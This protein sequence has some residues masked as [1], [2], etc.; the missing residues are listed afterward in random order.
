[1]IHH[2]TPTFLSLASHYLYLPIGTSPHQEYNQL[3]SHKSQ[4]LPYYLTFAFLYLF[5]DSRV[6]SEKNISRLITAFPPNEHI[7]LLLE[8]RNF[9]QL[10]Q[11]CKGEYDQVKRKLLSIHLD[12]VMN[13]SE[14]KSLYKIIKERVA[15]FPKERLW[16]LFEPISSF[17]DFKNIIN[18]L[19]LSDRDLEIN[20]L[21]LNRFQYTMYLQTGEKIDGNVE[22]LLYYY[23]RGTKDYRETKD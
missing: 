10:D 6:F 23:Y 2:Q 20:R 22:K 8:S 11:V 13:R 9:Q 19:R 14:S 16:D 12:M 4:L 15:S 18:R 1:M 3:T 7:W 21:C 5:N 17:K